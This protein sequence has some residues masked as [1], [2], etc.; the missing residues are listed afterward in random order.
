MEQI[1][2]LGNKIDCFSSYSALYQHLLPLCKSCT[3]ARYIT[4]NNVHTMM[5]GYRNAPFRSIINNS[6]ISIPDGKPLEIV[7]KLKGNKQIKRLFGPTIMANFIDWSQKDDIS[8]FF[9]GSSDGTLQ[10]LKTA[11]QENYP[12][13]KIAGMLSPPYLPMNEWNNQSFLDIINA[14]KPDIIWVGLG[15]PKQEIWMSAN[16]LKITNGLMIGI[17]AGFDYLSGKTQ[18]APNWMKN[19]S[20][21]WLYRLTQEPGRLWKRYLTTIPPF[22][23]LA[24]L[25][26]IG[27]KLKDYD[28]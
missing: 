16:Q 24:T 25:E 2:I 23:V 13:A 18:H 8:H 12:N 11:I 19:G 28:K 4:V 1:N 22:L 10:A 3:K 26:L 27:V 20:L 21:E 7:G 14:A 9:F 17:G 6:L 5:E 15:A